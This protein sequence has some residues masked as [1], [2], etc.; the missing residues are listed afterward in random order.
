MKQSLL[1]F[2]FLINVFV[3]SLDSSREDGVVKRA[4]V[5]INGVGG[6]HVTGIIASGSSMSYEFFSDNIEKISFR[7]YEKL[8]GYTEI[9]VGALNDDGTVI[10]SSYRYLKVET[11]DWQVISVIP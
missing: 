11:L 5:E 8:H 9:K 4:L 2:Y 3:S 10:E 6:G 7:L 1:Y